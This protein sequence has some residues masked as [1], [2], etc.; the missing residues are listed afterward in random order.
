M[1]SST[2][3]APTPATADESRAERDRPCHFSRLLPELTTAVCIAFGVSLIANT[4]LPNDGAWF[5]YAVLHH[6]GQRLYRDLHLVLQPLTVLE[7]QWWMSLAGKGWIVSKVPGV[8]HLIALAL[9]IALVTAKSQLTAF[10]KAIIIACAFFV[11]IHFEAYR[12]DDYHAI[13]GAIYVFSI[14]LLFKL[15][16]ASSSE[17]SLKLILVLGLLSGLA[18]TT[19]LTDGAALCLSNALAIAYLL[20][21]RKTIFLVGF[22]GL[23]FLVVLCIVFLTGDSLRDYASSTILGAA[24]PKGGL[25]SVFSRPLL[26]F[27]N[28]FIFLVV[29]QQWRIVLCSA[30]AAASWTWLIAPFSLAD[31]RRSTIRAAFG[32]V[33]FA[34]TIFLLLPVIE[35]GG[36]IVVLSAI[37]VIASY[38]V[39]FTLVW[40]IAFESLRARSAVITNPKRVILLLPFA[41]LLSG[42]MSSGGFHVGL[43]APIAFFVLTS[44]VLFPALFAQRWVGSCFLVIASLL[45]IS[46]AYCKAMNPASWQ[47]YKTFPI[48][49]HRLLV[50]H[51]TY[52][53]MVID[54]DLYGFF[55]GICSVTKNDGGSELLS[56]PYPYANY[57]CDMPPWQGFVQTFFDTSSKQVIDDLMTKL[58]HSPPR[59]ILYERQ[60]QNLALHEKTF[61][62]GR[63]LPHR[64]LDELIVGNIVSGRWQLVRRGIY[65][66]GNDWLLV[67]TQ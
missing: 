49:S 58:Q 4:Q 12:F 60:L 15:N 64:D 10:S 61:N 13:V 8:L 52:G 14:L 63:R 35:N 24:G 45:A 32:S 16:E 36:I 28:S 46:G 62:N 9:G 59:W 34:L 66:A 38:G 44:A 20:R 50:D 19:R 18:I 47:S 41:L 48:F 29:P 23:T 54:K 51:P 55:E 43:Y 65:G 56:I 26:L 2:T 67:R 37:L 22:F 40:S 57:Y 11:G 27:W 42:A 33:L 21:T 6:N 53:P 1:A 25:A 5:W 30:G 39:V 3:I 31:T 17:S 7:T